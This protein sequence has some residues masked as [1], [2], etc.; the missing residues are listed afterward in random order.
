MTASC[1]SDVASNSA[2]FLQ[3]AHCHLLLQSPQV[4]VAC[5][6]SRIL[7]AFR[8]R[9]RQDSMEC[10]LLPFSLEPELFF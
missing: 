9:E 7:V 5:V 2:C 3:S 4:A 10:C 6:F 8:R 1:Q